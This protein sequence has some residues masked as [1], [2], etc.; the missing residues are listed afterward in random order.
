LRLVWLSWKDKNHPLAGGAE[1]VTHNLLLRLARD[2]HEVTLL[3][4]RPAGS[5]AEEIIDGYKVIRL[6]NRYS[7]YWK[8]A[9]YY[10][11]HLRGHT[12]LVIEEINTI[13]FF[14]RFYTRTKTIL[15]FHQLA[16][17]VWFYQMIWPLN[18]VGY[19]LEPLYLRLLGKQPVI[20]VSDST[21]KDLCRYGFM[22][23]N[24]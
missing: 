17:V 6:G 3:T 10:K 12:D 11:K 7:V 1:K 15:F 22:A 14:S 9:R 13:P 8:A 18:W 19:I 24:I 23:S 5:K 16:R 20:T 21:K 2:G 4:A